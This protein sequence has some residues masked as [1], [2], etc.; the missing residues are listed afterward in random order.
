[1]IKTIHGKQ[2]FLQ[3]RARIEKSAY[4]ITHVDAHVIN[5]CATNQSA[6]KDRASPARYPAV[7]RPARFVSL[8][9]RTNIRGVLCTDQYTSVQGP[10]EVT[11]E[12]VHANKSRGPPLPTVKKHL[13]TIETLTNGLL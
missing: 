7:C 12:L 3:S 6:T 2:F 5:Y 4:A 10:R 13:L 9:C 1:M 8:Y 11:G